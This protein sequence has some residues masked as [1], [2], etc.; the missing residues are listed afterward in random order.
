M[1]PFRLSRVGVR[2][3]VSKLVLSPRRNRNLHPGRGSLT[4]GDVSF[5][6]NQMGEGECKKVE[7]AL[8]TNMI[9]FVNSGPYKN[10][11]NLEPRFILLIRYYSNTK[12]VP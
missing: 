2:N 11:D 5:L 8:L 12:F 9:T 4:E 6:Q 10:L 7:L 3:L 1:W